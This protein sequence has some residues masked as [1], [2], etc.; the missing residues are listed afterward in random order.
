MPRLRQN[1]HLHGR[2]T[3]VLFFQELE[4]SSKMQGLPFSTQIR[5]APKARRG[6]RAVRSQLPSPLQ[7]EAGERRRKA[8]SLRGMFHGEQISRLI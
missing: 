8:G 7:A 3:G 1:V 6:L 5:E 2:R 4:R